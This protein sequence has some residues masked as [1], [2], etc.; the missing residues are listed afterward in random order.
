[1]AAT[2]CLTT[3]KHVAS[4][5]GK[6]MRQKRKF[7]N[8]G[9]FCPSLPS[10]FCQV[11]SYNW[12]YNV[13][14]PPKPGNRYLICVDI[15]N[16]GRYMTQNIIFGNGETFCPGLPFSDHFDKGTPSRFSVEMFVFVSIPRNIIMSKIIFGHSSYRLFVCLSIAE[17][18]LQVGYV[19]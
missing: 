9:T 8:G 16:S 4:D 18:T 15:S 13:I 7:G 6:N 14:R 1:M 3:K 11:P 2:K 5:N 12:L 10:Q 19:R 17:D